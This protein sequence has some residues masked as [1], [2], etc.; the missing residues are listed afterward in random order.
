MCRRSISLVVMHRIV[1]DL[2]ESKTHAIA[3]TDCSGTSMIKSFLHVAWVHGADTPF[4]FGC[5]HA[6]GGLQDLYCIILQNGVPSNRRAGLETWPKSH[7][8]D[9]S[10][11][12][13][14]LYCHA[15]TIG[16]TVLVVDLH[17]TCTVPVFVHPVL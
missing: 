16:I 17:C 13:Q 5:V 3:D 4:F 14:Y 9:S 12:Q 6:H 8:R 1:I 15:D 2:H 10:V 11:I 7:S